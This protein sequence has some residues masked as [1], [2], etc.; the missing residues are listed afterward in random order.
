[1][2]KIKNSKTLAKRV[3]LTKT[4]KILKK[5]VRTGHLKSKWST[6]RRHRKLKL[7]RVR[8]TGYQK[9]IKRLLPNK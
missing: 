6:A 7:T 4:G 3:R 1:M 5:H 2:P 9:I 8:A